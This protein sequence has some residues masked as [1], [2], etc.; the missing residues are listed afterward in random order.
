MLVIAIDSLDALV[1]HSQ[2]PEETLYRLKRLAADLSVPIL[3][4]ACMKNPSSRNSHVRP[5]INELWNSDPIAGIV[6]LLVLLDRPDAY[7]LESSRAGEID[8]VV[9]KNRHGPTATVT[10]AFQGHYCRMVDLFSDAQRD[11]TFNTGKDAAANV[12][13]VG[14]G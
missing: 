4:T 13:E 2:R 3:V 11:W 12:Q 6:D 9:A 8:L 1:T 5:E 14:E 7:D 10:V